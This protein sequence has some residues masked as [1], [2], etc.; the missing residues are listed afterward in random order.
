MSFTQSGCM[1]PFTMSQQAYMPRNSPPFGVSGLFQM[2]QLYVRI[3]GL[4]IN[5]DK[6]DLV[7]ISNITGLFCIQ[8]IIYR[9]NFHNHGC[10]I[11]DITF[12]FQL[13]YYIKEIVCNTVLESVFFNRRACFY[14]IPCCSKN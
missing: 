12:E 3:S 9:G 7:W 1:D 10:Q 4:N 13:I 8:N 2:A 11:C 14:E 5:V 6:S